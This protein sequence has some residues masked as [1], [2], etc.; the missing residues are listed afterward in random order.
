M[1]TAISLA[2][3]FLLLV[4]GCDTHQQQ[5]CIP[6][7]RNKALESID[8]WCRFKFGPEE[9]RITGLRVRDLTPSPA[10]W[11]PPQEKCM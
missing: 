5:D 11:Q 8:R 4:V 3:I 6:G 9:L 1:R 7:Q 10:C 2:L